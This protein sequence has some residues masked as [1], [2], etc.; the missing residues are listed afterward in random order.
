MI[1]LSGLNPTISVELLLVIETDEAGASDRSL[2]GMIALSACT[3]EAVRRLIP[4]S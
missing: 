2:T 1:S 4:I 3:P